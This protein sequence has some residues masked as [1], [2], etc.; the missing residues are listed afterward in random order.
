MSKIC[1]ECLKEYE[2]GNFCLECGAKLVDAKVA[3]FCPN[4]QIIVPSGKFCPECGTKLIEKAIVDECIPET[5]PESTS[6]P[7]SEIVCPA[8][9]FPNEGGASICAA[10]GYP[11]QEEEASHPNSPRSGE[12]PSIDFDPETILSKYRDESGDIRDL[13]DEEWENAFEEITAVA[14]TGNPEAQY[15]L[16]SFYCFSGKLPNDF[17]KAYE[18]LRNAEKAGIKR[19]GAIL[20]IF[21]AYGIKVKQNINEAIKRLQGVKD[22]PEACSMLGDIYYDFTGEIDKARECYEYAASKEDRG[23]YSGLG[24]M[25]KDG[26]GV[27]QDYSKAYEYFNLAAAHGDPAAEYE[28]GLMFLNGLGTSQDYQQA[29]FW[30][31][32]SSNHGHAVAYNALAFMYLNGDGVEQDNE[33]ACE[34]FKK[35]AALENVEAMAELGNYY[36]S[37]LFDPKKAFEW[38]KKAADQGYPEA[39]WNLGDCYE[40]GIGVK[41]NKKEAEKYHQMAREAGFDLL[42]SE[43]QVEITPLDE[44]LAAI[45]NQDYETAV[46]ILRNLANGGN[47]EAQFEL[48][49]CYQSGT[50]VKKNTSVAAS[51]LNKSAESGYAPAYYALGQRNEMGIDITPNQEQA[52]KWYRKAAEQGLADA[53][54]R[55]GLMYDEGRGITQNGKK[56]TDLIKSAAEN[57]SQ[58]AKD[59]L[60]SLKDKPSA[61]INKVRFE[62]D[63]MY[64][65][66]RR[67][68]RVHVDFAISNMKDKE[69]NCSINFLYDWG[70]KP[71]PVTVDYNDPQELSA[72]GALVVGESAT[73]Q[74]KDTNCEDWKFDVPYYILCNHDCKGTWPIIARIIIWDMS[75][76]NPKELKTVDKRFSITYSKKLFSDPTYEVVIGK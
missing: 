50:G 68:L 12:I 14:N 17:D 18:L 9:G 11:L 10:C 24:K 6:E 74:F 53:Q 46:A 62:R 43:P 67:G 39:L 15:F 42:P 56:A 21:Y 59:Y 58:E 57:G 48:A 7:A 26:V 27:P 66:T 1:P 75:G 36:S 71:D 20:G 4:C 23:G 28:I 25:Y 45:E 31:T 5:K 37:V 64:S 8:C 13:S 35:S 16:A 60:K 32:E 34:L 52:A 69:F 19:A 73:S 49:K 72:D 33:K 40:H 70:A 55:L 63:I 41:E 29:I 44:A 61:S 65:S 38:T 2:S 47:P 51:W 76:K 30:F 22:N 3:L 54:F